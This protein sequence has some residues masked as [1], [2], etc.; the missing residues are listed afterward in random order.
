VENE[1]VG[2]NAFE[3]KNDP[4]CGE[5]RHAVEVFILTGIRAAAAKRR[6]KIHIPAFWP[7]A[8]KFIGLEPLCRR[9]AIGWFGEKE[10]LQA[11]LCRKLICL[12]KYSVIQRSSSL[13]I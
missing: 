2:A 8:C 3:A 12:I 13:L 5:L 4:A 11:S 10:K 6:K 1:T 9:S 7:K